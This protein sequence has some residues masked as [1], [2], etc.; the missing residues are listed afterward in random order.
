MKPPPWT[1]DERGVELLAP[2][3]CRRCEPWREGAVGEG[4]GEGAGVG[5]EGRWGSVGPGDDDGSE[6]VAWVKEGREEDSR[7]LVVNKPSGNLRRI[8]EERGRTGRE[9]GEESS[10]SEAVKRKRSGGAGPHAGGKK[11]RGDDDSGD[12]L[13]PAEDVPYEGRLYSEDSGRYTDA[14]AIDTAVYEDDDLVP[15]STT[16]PSDPSLAPSVSDDETPAHSTSA[17]TPLLD[18][19]PLVPPARAHQPPPRPPPPASPPTPTRPSPQTLPTSTPPSTLLA[20][21]STLLT[22][23][24]LRRR[25]SV[26]TMPP[27][28]AG[29]RLPL[30]DAASADPDAHTSVSV[31]GPFKTRYHA[32]SMR[33]T[34]C[35]RVLEGGTS[36]FELDEEGRVEVS[37]RRCWREGRIGRGWGVERVDFEEMGL[38]FVG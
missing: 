7:R 34:A 15:P 27:H 4:E 5:G 8:T 17:D 25:P 23:H 3:V 26:P 10:V 36:W 11:R 38:G 24:L 12:V 6:E 19:E 21:L 2:P 33:C 31:R 28:C 1:D 18:R 9:R 13:W 35:E 30:L 20:R 14:D 32:R 37:C 29:C 22:T 16:T